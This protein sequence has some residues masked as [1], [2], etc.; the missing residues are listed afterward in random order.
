MCFYDISIFYISTISIFCY[1]IKEVIKNE[2]F[3]FTPKGF[4]NTENI[5]MNLRCV[6][7]DLI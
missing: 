2:T 3:N 5:I 6:Y 4:S 7:N 1:L